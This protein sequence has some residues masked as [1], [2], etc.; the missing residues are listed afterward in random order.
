LSEEGCSM[1]ILHIT[2]KEPDA[3]TKKII[4]IHKAGNAVM[5]IDLSTG[6][7]SY[8]KLVATVF[9]SDKVFCW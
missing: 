6:P 8:D 9:A 4:E 2:K 7:V 1:N 5:V 3:S